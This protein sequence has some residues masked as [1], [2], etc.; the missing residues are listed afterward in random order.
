MQGR[1][2]VVALRGQAGQ[3]PCLAVPAQLPL[4][5]LGQIGQ[6]ADVG[7]GDPVGLTGLDQSLTRV[8][9]DGLQEV[10]A[11]VTRRST[12][13]SE[14]STRRVSVSTASVRSGSAPATA[15]TAS[16]DQVPRKTDSRRSRARS[17]R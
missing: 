10:V 12:A 15:W 4:G 5:L 13:T 6:V 17:A 11:L 1:L 8:L 3:P 14:R 2:D 9:P 7:P 16:S